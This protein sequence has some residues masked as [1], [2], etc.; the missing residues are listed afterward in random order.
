MIDM[1]GKPEVIAYMRE[2]LKS[3]DT[4]ASYIHEKPLEKGRIIAVVPE[5]TKPEALLQF[6]VGGVG[7]T[8]PK[9][10]LVPAITDYLEGEGNRYA[11][12]ETLSR[13]GDEGLRRSEEPYFVYDDEVYNF[14]HEGVLSRAS[15]R[16]VVVWARRYPPLVGILSRLASDRLLTPREQVSDA[17]LREL[18]EGMD[19]L[20]IGAYDDEAVLMWSRA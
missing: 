4:L 1:S 19:H 12:F 20:F 6:D 15:A 3:G 13:P 7:E 10:F 16:A 5:T 18:A 8:D 11:V 17:F 9:D 2:S 14:L